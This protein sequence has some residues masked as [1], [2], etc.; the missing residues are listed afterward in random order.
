M[1]SFLM[2]TSGPDAPLTLAKSR[3]SQVIARAGI[4]S[5]RKAEDLIT[6]GLVKVNGE[7]ILIP[8]HQVIADKDKVRS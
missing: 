1:A 3:V 4:A 2:Y 6:E 7:K 5:R 8:Q